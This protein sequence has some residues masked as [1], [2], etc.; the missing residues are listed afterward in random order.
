VRP[1]AR[2]RALAAADRPATLAPRRWGSPSTAAAGPNRP[3]LMT[4]TSRVLP[5]WWGARPDEQAP[6]EVIPAGLCRFPGRG[7]GGVAKGLQDPSPRPPAAGPDWWLL[8][9]RQK[10]LLLMLGGALGTYARYT[11]GEW[12]AGQSWAQ[13]FPYGTLIINVTGSFVLG[14]AAVVL[15]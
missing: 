5:P 15:L 6:R 13:G 12:V 9:A 2:C 10:M 1:T 3:P 14:F 4:P 11:L 8:L 7:D